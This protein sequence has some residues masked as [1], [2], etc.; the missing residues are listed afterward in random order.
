[1]NYL[2]FAPLPVLAIA[3]VCDLRTRKVPNWLTFPS[4][5]AGLALTCIFRNGAIFSCLAGMAVFFCLGALG[6]AGMGD[7]KL[8]MVLASVSGI[9]ISASAL[10]LASALLVVAGL[11]FDR[12][13]AI[14]AIKGAWLSLWYRELAGKIGGG[15]KIAF[16]P[17][18]AAG[19][20]IAAGGAL[21]WQAL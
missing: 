15:K 10:G 14:L 2:L 21:I 19:Y 9:L 8:L 6:A 7:I 17:Y 4:M 13:E 20:A 16:A 3:A 1:M 5:I 18:I 12:Q 11:I